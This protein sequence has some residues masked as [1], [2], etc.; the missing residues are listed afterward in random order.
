MD[1]D[2]Q[3][4]HDIEQAIAI[5][6][7]SA[8]EE[9]DESEAIAE[10]KALAAENRVAEPNIADATMAQS[11]EDVEIL[12]GL[13]SKGS[14]KEQMNQCKAIEEPQALSAS[15]SPAELE[16][17]DEER[18]ESEEA[19]MMTVRSILSEGYVVLTCS[20]SVAALFHPSLSAGQA[21]WKDTASMLPFKV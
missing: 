3:Y 5:S 21:S 11:D 20:P 10:S 8:K 4:S 9:M 18:E 17:A 7:E 12:E 6:K 2:A 14:A 15:N 1:L 13:P 19:D 16:R